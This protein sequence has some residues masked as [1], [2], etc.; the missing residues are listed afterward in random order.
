ML[1][2]REFYINGEWVSPAKPNDYHVIDPTTEEPCAVISLG[3]QADTDA[4]VAA[5]KAALPGWMAT[6]PAERIALLEKLL[7]VYQ[8]RAEDL[9]KAMS[10]AMGAPMDL[11]RTSQVGAGSY[12]LS[13]FI[14]AAK[15]FKF[16][17]P[18]GDHAPNDRI[19]REAVGV[20]GLITPWN[21]PMN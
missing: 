7:E 13:N 18:L 4:A 5:A 12:H 14:K 19:I 8:A 6:P 21:W 15:E 10:T 2:K 3:D 17:Q 11:A 20:A 16:E 1:E 9:A